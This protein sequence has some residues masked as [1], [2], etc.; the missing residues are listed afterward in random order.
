MLWKGTGQPGQEGAAQ[1]DTL[2]TRAGW[3]DRAGAGLRVEWG[4][5]CANLATL[6][7]CVSPRPRLPFPGEMFALAWGRAQNQGWHLTQSDCHG[8]SGFPGATGRCGHEKRGDMP[9][10]VSNPVRDV[11][12]PVLG[13]CASLLR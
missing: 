8:G 3:K 12:A 11:G 6:V 10:F 5:V 13:A 1:C 2:G 9:G 7:Q 4:G